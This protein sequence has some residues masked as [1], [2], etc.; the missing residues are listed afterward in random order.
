MIKVKFLGKFDTLALEKDKIYDVISI[1]RGW[2]RIMT[3][4]DD[5]YLFPPE[6]FQIVSVYC[7]VKNGQVDGG[8][9]MIICDVADRYVKPSVLPKGVEWNEEQRE[10]CLNCKWHNDIN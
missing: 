5:D 8:D 2:Y 9:C 4:L 10:K 6:H 1:E 7:P 3:E